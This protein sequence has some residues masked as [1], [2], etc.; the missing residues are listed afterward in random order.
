MQVTK[1]DTR[2]KLKPVELL[3][4]LWR[5][6]S[7][8]VARL[9]LESYFRSVWLWGEIVL[10]LAFFAALFFPFLEYRS[11]FYGTSNFDMSGIAILGAAIMVRH[12]TSARVYVL[13]ARLPARAAYS[14]GL[15]LATALLRVPLFLLLLVLVLIAGRLIDPV[16]GPMAIGALGLLPNIILVSV[17][18]VALS[19]PMARRIDRIFFLAWLAAALFSLSPIIQLPTSFINVLSIVR[20]PILPLAACFQIS[21]SGSIGWSDTWAF[22]VVACYVVGLAWLAGYWLERRELLLH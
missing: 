22:I 4:A 6:P 16:A 13:L 15:M 5:M 21:T 11:Y 10:V 20:I 7:V 3:S 1:R 14:R 12:S 18:T 2:L 17:L 19:S 8:T 9:L